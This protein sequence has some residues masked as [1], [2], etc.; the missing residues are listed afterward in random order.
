MAFWIV[1]LLSW[2]VMLP[3]L[4]RAFS[5]VPTPERLGQSRMIE[6]PTLETVAMIAVQSAIELSV[7]LALLFP[8][9]PRRYLARLWIAAVALGIWF[10][11]STPLSLT[12]VAWV[13]RRWLA[14]V[15]G[16]LLLAALGVTAAWLLAGHG[17]RAAPDRG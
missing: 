10:I 8:W 7:A 6:I 16:A 5:T 14:A 17:R 2:V 13:H 9:R 1:L 3:A 11:A 4:W 15:D 12:H